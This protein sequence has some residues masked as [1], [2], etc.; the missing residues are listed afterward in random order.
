MAQVFFYSDIRTL[1]QHINELNKHHLAAAEIPVTVIDTF[2]KD[3]LDDFN[4]DSRAFVSKR[5]TVF[6][7][8][9]Y[10]STKMLASSR[11]GIR[12]NTYL[13][14]LLMGDF[15]PESCN[16]GI[17]EGSLALLDRLLMSFSYQEIIAHIG[18][19][20]QKHEGKNLHKEL[21]A[22]KRLVVYLLEAGVVS[23][24]HEITAYLEKARADQDDQPMFKHLHLLLVDEPTLINQLFLTMYLKDLVAR[25]SISISIHVL[26]EQENITMPFGALWAQ[27]LRSLDFLDIEGEKL[28]HAQQLS[29]TASQPNPELATLKQSLS[30]HGATNIKQPTGSA[31]FLRSSNVDRQYEEVA[32]LI[33]YLLDQS[34]GVQGR[35]IQRK[36]IQDREVQ[37]KEIRVPDHPKGLSIDPAKIKNIKVVSFDVEQAESLKRTLNFR[38]YSVLEVQ[39]HDLKHSSFTESMINFFYAL[40]DRD[41]QELIR[42]LLSDHSALTRSQKNKFRKQILGKYYPA[43]S[44]V[45]DLATQISPRFER[46]ISHESIV[47]LM[48][49]RDYMSCAEAVD[50]Y[51]NHLKL[52]LPLY[53]LARRQHAFAWMRAIKTNNEAV[54]QSYQA[55]NF[56]RDHYPIEPDDGDGSKDHSMAS[57]SD[58]IPQDT[59]VQYTA[60]KFK[61]R[62]YLK[63]LTEGSFSYR[64]GDPAARIVFTNLHQAAYSRHDALIVLGFNSTN[65]PAFEPDDAVTT[66]MKDLVSLDRLSPYECKRGWF[67]QALDQTDYLMVA[68][69]LARDR[70]GDEVQPAPLL[71]ELLDVYRKSNETLKDIPA[72]VQD[73]AEQVRAV[74]ADYRSSVIGDGV[75]SQDLLHHAESDGGQ[76]E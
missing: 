59:Q 24:A 58:N 66:M 70:R 43:W 49:E 42:Y 25:D 3:F 20:Q 21:D 47:K 18:E 65:F 13:L 22:I 60:K 33:E 54:L 7:L 56:C 62:F 10:Q 9:Q 26:G 73:V 69:W 51:L 75:A 5:S 48:E 57:H 74:L 14:K 50:V 34:R 23:P 40:I 68:T 52:D 46:L 30:R 15:L 27:W 37:S 29:Q 67:A 41:E 72:V 61:A 45:I 4:Q 19:Y 6:E 63:L 64:E 28:V 12:L 39:S 1:A 8:L 36:E 44:D 31:V 2:V 32:D 55:Y 71:L 35:E 38:G 16:H 17:K 11:H 53:A 76:H